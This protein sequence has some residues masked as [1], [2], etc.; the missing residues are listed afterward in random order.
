MNVQR[1]DTR[2]YFSH[3]A[4]N[5]NSVGQVASILGGA[6]EA[7]VDI[8]EK[9]QQSKIANYR[10]DLS[11]KFL[12]KNNEINLKYQSDPTNPERERELKETFDSMADGYKI[13][14]VSQTQWK[15]VKDDV[16]NRYKQ[17]NAD[18]QIKQQQ[19]NVQ[20]DLKN[21]YES[22][23]NQIS[24]LGMNGA[25]IEEMRLIY[26]SG[27]E[28]LKNGA[29]SALG[30]EVVENFL[31]DSNHD[32]MTTYISSLAVDNPLQAQ[33]LLQNKGVQE[34]IGNAETIEKLNSYVA[35]S[36]QNQSKRTAV[37]ELGN[38]LRSMNSADAENILD[39]KANLN[40]VMKFIE[41]NKNL[42][43]GSKDLILDIYGIGSKT[44]YVY[45]REKKKIVKKPERG[46][47][48]RGKG[49]L[50]SLS[51][52]SKMEKIDCA[53]NLELALQDMFSFSDT[54]HINPKK[55][56][57]NNTASGINSLVLN[58][59]QG[60]AEAQGALDTA[61]SAGIIDKQKRQKLMNSYIQPM[62]DYLEANLIE[63]DE[64]K[65]W[66]GTKLGYGNIKRAFDVENAGRQK[67]AVRKNLLTA[68]G[69][70]YSALDKAR[71]S[72]GFSS[73]YD[74]ETLP[75]GEQQKIYKTASD[76]AIAN[77]KKFGE[78]PELFFKQEYPQL[79]SQ[80]ISLFGV[81]D[82]TDVAK[83]VA[84]EVYNAPEDKKIDVAKVM[85]DAIVN[86]KSFKKQQATELV[87]SIV[88]TNKMY[89]EGKVL[90]NYDIE[91]RANALGL[92][93]KQLTN[94]AYSKG[95]SPQ[96]YLIYLENL[97]RNKR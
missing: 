7:G 95:V 84:Q 85:S 76:T 11:T 8:A 45:D 73:I 37:N 53:N 83:K 80:G 35:S 44:E 50:S 6:V 54:E 32:I 52:M 23:N 4:E 60:V 10:V 91:P 21:G 17:Y 29:I 62:T 89:G 65:G 28:G 47:H 9:A 61:Y 70:Y 74:L 20:N 51:K 40:Q 97:K 71:K 3:E 56:L 67:N 36:I 81:K 42:P 90:S 5:V 49:S 87:N 66:I 26:D 27:I 13:N 86:M 96:M 69:Y 39:G 57:K 19:S 43:E 31:K 33:K 88:A 18:W 16:Y 14:P 68:Q 22:L 58:R 12:A 24:M 1:G 38:T 46:G 94:D 48:G 59:L 41:T 72:Y 77:A 63:L 34:D 78:H 15:L 25:S 82:G 75:S 30:S 79:Y 2:Q 64:R 55:V 92:T 93:M